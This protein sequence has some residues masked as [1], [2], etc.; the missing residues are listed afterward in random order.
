[1]W[2]SPALTISCSS[3]GSRCKCADCLTSYLNTHDTLSKV[4]RGRAKWNPKVHYRPRTT[5]I[6]SISRPPTIYL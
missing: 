4:S 1:L 3:T 6:Y 5:W 2:A